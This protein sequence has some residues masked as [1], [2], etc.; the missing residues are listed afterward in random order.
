M[1]PFAHPL[2]LNSE[3]VYLEKADLS[4]MSSFQLSFGFP[5]LSPDAST[6]FGIPCSAPCT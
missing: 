3:V 4:T 1:A 5:P 2:A 6:S